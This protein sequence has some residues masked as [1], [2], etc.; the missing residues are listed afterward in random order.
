MRTWE[1]LVSLTALS[2]IFGGAA[3]AYNRERLADTDLNRRYQELNRTRF[4]GQL[5]DVSVRWDNLHA[6][7]AYGET[8]QFQDGS[9]VIV[10]DKYSVTTERQTE[11]V[12][13]HEACHVWVNWQETDEHGPKFRECMTRYQ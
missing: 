3:Y 1:K 7:E 6:D 12:L 13:E 11:S 9:L 5:P 4:D 2:V 10:L 8:R